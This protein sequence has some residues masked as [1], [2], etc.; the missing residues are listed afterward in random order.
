MEKIQV[1]NGKKAK[2]WF[3]RWKEAMSEQGASYARFVS[4]TGKIPD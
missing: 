3:Q 4:A 1:A 2:S